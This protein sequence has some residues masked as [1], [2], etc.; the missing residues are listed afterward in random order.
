MSSASDW[1]IEQM[2]LTE[3]RGWK[4]MRRML[5]RSVRLARGDLGCEQVF[6]V[7][8]HHRDL[9]FVMADAPALRSPYQAGRLD[10]EALVELPGARTD[11]VVHRPYVDDDVGGVAVDDRRHARDVVVGD[12]LVAS[13]HVL[14]GADDA[15][16]ALDETVRRP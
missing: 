11:A 12:D 14:H 3:S 8:E 5:S 13:D 7:A 4:D 16:A 10:A 15:V 1:F 6:P 2:L 9:P